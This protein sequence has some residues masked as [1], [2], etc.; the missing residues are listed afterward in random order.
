M[1]LVSGC[2]LSHPSA[3]LTLMS[4]ALGSPCVSSVHSHVYY[5]VAKQSAAV[6]SRYEG[7]PKRGGDSDVDQ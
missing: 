7:E 3:H 1:L 6:L 5:S 4:K 2:D